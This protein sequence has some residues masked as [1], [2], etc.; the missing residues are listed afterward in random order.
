[1]EQS[2]LF[3]NMIDPKLPL[4]KLEM[5]D[6]FMVWMDD[7]WSRGHNILIHCNQGHSRAPSL[8]MLFLAKYLKV[9]SDI[10]YMAAYSQYRHLDPEF[11]PNSGIVLFLKTYWNQI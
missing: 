1:M 9:I 8:A 10:D 11:N 4:F 6:A 7:K 3:L 2:D 5:F